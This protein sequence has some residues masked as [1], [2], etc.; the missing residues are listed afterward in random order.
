[1]RVVDRRGPSAA[2]FVGHIGPEMADN[3]AMDVTW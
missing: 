1:M 3:R 2:E